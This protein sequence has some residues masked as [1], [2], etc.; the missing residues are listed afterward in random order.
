MLTVT[1]LVIGL[2]AVVLNDLGLRYGL[3]ISLFPIVILAMTIERAA[4]M[5][6]EEGA[7]ETAIAVLGSLFVATVGYFC[8]GNPY[9]QHW[10]FVFPELLLVVLAITILL[11]RYNGYK[12]T[13]YFR[14]LALQKQMQQA[15]S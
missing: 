9:V 6:E 10:A 3:S 12:L 2:L 7:K 4:V 15:E 5:L 11:G 1:V 13:E 8:I 14:F